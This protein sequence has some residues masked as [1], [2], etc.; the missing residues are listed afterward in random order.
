[1]SIGIK[2][3]MAWGFRASTIRELF[4]SKERYATYQLINHLRMLL[5]NVA[6]Y[7]CFVGKTQT[8]TNSSQQ[9]M[10]GGMK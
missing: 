6:E 2:N 9:K 1:M 7:G 10:G 8:N 5:V 3:P 4:S